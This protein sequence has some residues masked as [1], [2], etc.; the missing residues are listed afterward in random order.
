[1]DNNNMTQEE[2]S[3]LEQYDITRYE[4]PSIAADIAIFS[5][6]EEGENTNFRKLAKKALK[7]LL[8]KRGNY[9][10]KDCWAL[11]GGFC[12]PEEDV[13][14]TAKRELYEETNV[15]DVYLKPFGIFGETGR[16]PRGWIVSNAFLA[17]MDS[18]DCML[19]A[20]T[21]AW[22]AQWFTVELTKKELKKT[23]DVDSIYIE[24]EYILNFLK[25]EDEANFS[26][27]VREYKQFEHY[28]E[29]V[30]YEILDNGN[31]AFDHGKIILQALLTLRKEVENDS[32]IA[33]DL[34]PELFTLTQ[35]QT[36]FEV[37]LHQELLKANFRRKIAD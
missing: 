32:R 11:P 29:R 20:G 3:F 14:E 7:I 26:V 4:R 30:R 12:R 33:F 37:I 17:L 2:K 18:K 25:Q 10:Y 16:D 27:K 6:R 22:E 23:I 8:I 31:L 24:T 1:M 13:Y 5:I 19:R 28:H 35:L 21:D 36:A 34:M 15:K 9:P